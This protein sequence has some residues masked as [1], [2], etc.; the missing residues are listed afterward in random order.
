M[1]TFDIT[2]PYTN[3]NHIFNLYAIGDIHGGT[4]HCQV[5]RVDSAIRIL[6]NDPFCAV[7][8]M[9]DYGEFINP[10]DKRFDISSIDTS[11]VDL[12]NIC[13]SQEKWIA[14]KFKKLA[15]QKKL[16]VLLEGN[17]EAQRKAH[18][19]QDVMANIC[20]KL[21]V[22][23]GGHVACI[24][25]FFDREH[26]NETHMFTCM[27]THGSSGATTL[28][29]KVGALVAFMSQY[30]DTD[31]F[32]YAHTHAL[33]TDVE[34]PKLCVTGKRGFPKV[35]DSLRNGALTGSYFTTY[36]QDTSPS[37]GEKKNYSPNTLGCVRY[38]LNIETHDVNI[39]KVQ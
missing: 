4:K 2:V 32:G 33:V 21:N 31:L 19:N 30:T 35:S 26:S 16:K 34:I 13:T 27:F 28:S 5:K 29:G 37:Y 23:N 15:G 10:G 12:A 25:F 8:G 36:T 20:E 3:A 38:E 1:K 39:Y 18:D 7:I 24:R 9:G 17:H 6:E 11:Y 22:P 14:N